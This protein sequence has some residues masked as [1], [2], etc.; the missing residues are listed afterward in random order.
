M[1]ERFFLFMLAAYKDETLEIRKKT[2]LLLLINSLLILLIVINLTVAEIIIAHDLLSAAMEAGMIAVLAVSLVLLKNKR[3]LQASNITLVLLAIA[4]GSLALISND[5]RMNY[6]LAKTGLYMIP[7][8]IYSSLI[9]TKKYQSLLASSMSLVFLVLV[10]VAYPLILNGYH[11]NAGDIAQF[12][13]SFIVVTSAGLMSYLILKNNGEMIG[14]AEKEAGINL[15]KNKKIE[16]IVR[17]SKAG[18]SVGEKLEEFADRTLEL[19][20]AIN[21]SL[22]QIKKE[23]MFLNAIIKSSLDSNTAMQDSSK[24]V[25]SIIS[26]QNAA[27]NE[28]SSSVEEIT[29]SMNNIASTTSAKKESIDRLVNIA[30]DS[31]TEMN[32]SIRS[33]QEM[34]RSAEDM[35]GIIKVIQDVASQTNVLAMNAA[36]EASHA[37]ASG[38]GFAI[39]AAEIRKLSVETDRNSKLI[40][41]TLKKNLEDIDRTSRINIRAGDYFQKMSAEVVEVKNSMEEIIIGVQEISKGTGNILEAVTEILKMSGEV[42]GS[43]NEVDTRINE[44]NGNI[45]NIAKFTMELK[46][47]IESMVKSFEDII[48]VTRLIDK[49]GKE[50]TR[51]SEILDKEISNIMQ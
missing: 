12:A 41:A 26:E 6:A 2:R 51:N 1:I 5:T 39:V 17:A 32:Q 40:S 42:D 30:K 48:H 7:V 18:L 44:S 38:K 10:F 35:L 36:I 50:N 45:Q 21:K 9:G 24:K 23:T 13:T 20:N 29:R 8:I 47:K 16:G 46:Q 49:A 11:Y 31:E 22:E 34:S 28:T 43:M 33:I 19:V 14:I 27:V 4:M 3:F 25:K 37:G 15:E